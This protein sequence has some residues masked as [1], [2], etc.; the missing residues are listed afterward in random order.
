VNFEGMG[1]LC[2]D[3]RLCERVLSWGWG[4]LGLSGSKKAAGSGAGRTVI[5]RYYFLEIIIKS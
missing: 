5:P 4:M 2:R 3:W 1:V